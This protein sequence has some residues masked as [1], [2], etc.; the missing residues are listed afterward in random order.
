MTETQL[1]FGEEVPADVRDREVAS[2]VDLSSAEK[3]FRLNG[4]REES[5]VTIS[6]DVKTVTKWVLSIPESNIRWVRVDSEGRI[7]AV[8]AQIPRGYIHLKPKSRKSNQLS[9]MVSYGNARGENSDD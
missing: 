4:S 8:K 7:V 6:S 9:Q 5:H 3:E 1:L 2:D